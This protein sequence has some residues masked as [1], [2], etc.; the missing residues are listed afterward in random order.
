MENLST[1]FESIDKFT[2]EKICEEKYYQEVFKA[3]KTKL[4]EDQRNSG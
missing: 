3:F 4:N 2:T 1:N